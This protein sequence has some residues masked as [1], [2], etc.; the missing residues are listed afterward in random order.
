MENFVIALEINYVTVIKKMLS[1]FYFQGQ[2]SG[3]FVII[4]IIFIPIVK[5][6]N[7]TQKVQNL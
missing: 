4:L 1:L 3:I 7:W 5:S 6:N 2:D